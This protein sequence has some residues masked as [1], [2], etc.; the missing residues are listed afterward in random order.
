MDASVDV[1]PRR[2][3]AFG[4]ERLGLIGLRAPL[5]TVALIV[6]VSAL[7]A[8]GLTMVPREQWSRFG[9]TERWWHKPKS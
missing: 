8:W 4:L 5:V 2:S 3:F 6:L 1:P 7:A 9:I